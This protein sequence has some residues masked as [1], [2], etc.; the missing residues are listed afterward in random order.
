MSFGKRRPRLSRAQLRPTNPIAIEQGRLAR[1]RERLARLAVVGL[2]VLATSAIIFG[3]GPPFTY[4][5]GQRPNREIRVNVEKFERLNQK[6]S[7]AERQLVVDQI[8]PSLVN[9]PAPL[10]DHQ[11]RLEDLLD[12]VAKAPAWNSSR[13]T[14]ARAGG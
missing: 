11:S 14:S 2:A 6:K 13:R 10:R 5:L 7:N 4:R 1:Q 3:A 9:D 12:S 8:A